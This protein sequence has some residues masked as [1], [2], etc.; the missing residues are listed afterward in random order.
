MKNILFVNIVFTMLNKIG[1]NISDFLEKGPILFC[2]IVV[3]QGLQF[4]T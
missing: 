1:P 2:Q 4:P 3:Y